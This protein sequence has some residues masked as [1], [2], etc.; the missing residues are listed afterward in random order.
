MA[1]LH[2]LRP[3]FTEYD[4]LKT[5]VEISLFIS[6]S[7]ARSGCVYKRNCFV[8]LGLFPKAKNHDVEILVPVGLDIGGV[9]LL[10]SYPDLVIGVLRNVYFEYSPQYV[11][12]VGRPSGYETMVLLDVGRCQEVTG[13]IKMSI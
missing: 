1:L 7:L 4:D 13:V 6:L 10:V 12:S 9:V 11:R 3:C 8:E 5:M 2:Q